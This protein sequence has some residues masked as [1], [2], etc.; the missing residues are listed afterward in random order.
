MPPREH[1]PRALTRPEQPHQLLAVL[2]EVRS[3]RGRRRR[4]FLG[5]TFARGTVQHGLLRGA[6]TSAHPLGKPT[7]PMSLA[8]FVRTGAGANSG[9]PGQRAVAVVA[10]RSR[11]AARRPAGST[12]TACRRSARPAKRDVPAGRERAAAAAREQDRHVEVR[13]RVAVLDLA[14]EEHDAVV[15]HARRRPRRSRPCARAG[16]RAARPPRCRSF[17]SLSSLSGRP[18]GARS[19]GGRR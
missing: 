4:C 14:R 10:E 18:G 9:Q 12:R 15:E 2:L 3:N 5:S 13:V 1:D 7:R 11:R 19:R 16:R 17:V 6:P 8:R